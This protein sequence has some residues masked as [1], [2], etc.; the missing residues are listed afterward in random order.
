MTKLTIDS[1]SED[2]TTAI[3]T[4]LGSVL[5]AGDVV[6]L[7]G[8]MGA[9]KTRLVRGI[10]R[11]M[12]VDETLVNS[13]TY[14]VMQHY[15]PAPPGTGPELVHAD[16]YRLS[17]AD[18]LETLGF[19]RIESLLAARR[20]VLVV[21]WGERLSAWTASQP[22]TLRVRIEPT[23][24]DHRRLELSGSGALPGRSEWRFLDAIS[25]DGSG[26]ALPEGWTRC[27]VT[28]RPVGPG[29]PTFPFFDAKARDADLGRWFAG[30]YTLSRDLVPEDLDDPDLR[31]QD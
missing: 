3:G 24:T 1:A 9:G 11:G 16:A 13:P 28:R 4:V 17:G 10:A 25:G 20:C 15:P 18:E 31:Q 2:T 26:G 7:D 8:P 19:D 22:V 6:L 12:G 21:E 27:P 14:I 30:N 5:R 23:G 29:H